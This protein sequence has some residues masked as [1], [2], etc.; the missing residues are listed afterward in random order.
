MNLRNH[1]REAVSIVGIREDDVQVY[2]LIVA[3]TNPNIPFSDSV[4]NSQRLGHR[5]E[6]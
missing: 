2:L 3:E 1:E 5:Y 4:Q 6:V